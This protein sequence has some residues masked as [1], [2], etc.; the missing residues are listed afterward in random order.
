MNA[1]DDYTAVAIT[2]L[3]RYTGARVNITQEATIGERRSN[4]TG[5]RFV[6]QAPTL[7]DLQDKL[8]AT[9]HYPS[10]MKLILGQSPAYQQRVLSRPECIFLVKT[11]Q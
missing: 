1:G 10:Q 5:V 8:A 3:A 6:L 4:E 9:W 2:N 7:A 11:H